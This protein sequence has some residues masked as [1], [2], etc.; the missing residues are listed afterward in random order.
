LRAIPNKLGGVV[1]LLLSILILIPLAL[2]S[3]L[4]QFNYKQGPFNLFWLFVVFFFL[5][6]WLGIKPVEEPFV[7]LR[8][9]LTG[10]YFAWFLITMWE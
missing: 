4:N 9:V 10:A 7:I 8:I 1:G 6:T 5:L 3:K 2:K